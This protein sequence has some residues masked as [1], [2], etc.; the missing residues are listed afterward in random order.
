MG[1]REQV[2]ER[3]YRD[4]AYGCT[5]PHTKPKKMVKPLPGGSLVRSE[6]QDKGGKEFDFD[7]WY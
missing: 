5:W 7:L 3:E 2:K 6:K 4:I 1:K